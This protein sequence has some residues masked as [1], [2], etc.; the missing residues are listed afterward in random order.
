[1]LIALALLFSRLF[2]YIFERANQPPVIG[3][4]ISGVLLGALG[5]IL[6]RGQV[7]SIAGMSVGMPHLNYTGA[8]F[9]VL[10]DIGILFLLFI[11]GL[12]T[13]L[14]SLKK[15]GKPSLAVALGGVFVP[16]GFGYISA[17]L[18]DFTAAE[19][20][21]LGLI[22]VATSVGVTVRA[23][24]DMDKLNSKAGN[25]ILGAAVID[26]IFGVLLLAFALGLS[27]PLAIGLKIVLFFIVFLYIGLRVIERLL[28][29]GEKIHLPKAFLS[30]SIAIFLFYVYIAEQFD[31]AGIIGAFVAGILIGKSFKSRH[32]IDDIETVGYG[33]FIPLFFVWV[34]AV[35][36]TDLYEHPQAFQGILPFALVVLVAAVLGKILGCGL[37][38]RL[39]GTSTKE[40]L[41][42]GVG[43]IPRMELA[44]IIVTSAIYQGV[45]AQNVANTF[46][47]TTVIITVVTTIISPF[48]IKLTFK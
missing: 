24:M 31:I 47:A 44:L 27:S 30:Y 6:F 29:F 37:G 33:F 43:M 1:M 22:L 11:S 5:L 4:I 25:I 14:K 45:I 10:A 20:I 32:L 12:S 8:D 39:T 17:I 35:L 38:A 40:S 7:V 23:L 28:D 41:Q 15:L 48:L 26:D 18:F 2:G 34:G 9:Q 16:F 21:I 36:I 19:S 3:E 42:I 46:L 13:N